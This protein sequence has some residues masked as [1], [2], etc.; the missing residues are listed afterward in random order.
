[1]TVPLKEKDLVTYKNNQLSQN[2]KG[3]WYL[4]ALGMNALGTFQDGH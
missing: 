2:K 1:M 3:L 4:L